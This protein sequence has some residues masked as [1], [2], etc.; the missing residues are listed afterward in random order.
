MKNYSERTQ[1]ILSKASAEKRK[2][3]R[4]TAAVSSL[5]CLALVVCVSL[6]LL[7]SQKNLPTD[8]VQ[9]SEDEYYPI[10]TKLSAYQDAHKAPTSFWD[11]MFDGLGMV[12]GSINGSVDMAPDAALPEAVPDFGVDLEGGSNK[13]EEVTDNQVQG[14]GEADRIKRSSEYI[15]YLRGE[16]LYVYS[17][18]GES[19]AEIGSFLLGDSQNL[20][21]YANQREMY[22]SADCST[23]T[24]LSPVY[25][26]GDNQKY[27]VALNLD[28]TD[29]TNIKESGR[30]YVVG[31]YLSSRFIN[32]T[33][34]LINQYTPGKMDF[35]DP[36]TFVPY[37]GTPENNKCIPMEDIYSPEELTSA[38]YTVI[39][40]LDGK[41]LEMNDTAAYLSYSTEVYVSRD[42]IYLTRSF[43]DTIEAGDKTTHTSR[44]EIS[45]LRYDS[46]KLE[47]KGSTIIDGRILNQYSMDQQEDILRVVTTIDSD[48][49]QKTSDGEMSSVAF[50]DS[51]LSASLYCIDL[52]TWETVASVEAFAPQGEEVR[53]VRFDGNNAYVCTSIV[54]TD[55]V[56]FFDLSDLNNITCKDT[57]TIDGYSLSLVDFAEG[58][59]M[60][61]GYGAS[62]DTLK[63]ELYQEGSS[64]AESY[65]KYELPYASFSQEYKACYIDRENSLIGLAVLDYSGD[66]SSE[67]YYLLLHF[68]GYELNE[69]TRIPIDGQLDMTRGVY[70]DDWFYVLSDSFAVEKIG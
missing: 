33:L 11:A 40:K 46:E 41:T 49:Y 23:I 55:P 50:L 32:G 68:D 69:V 21:R 5:T 60:G 54:L 14:V 38:R 20:A 39:C 70:I 25:N 12:G 22:L 16:S 64:T 7:L 35:T 18:A 31:N 24:I 51:V 27:T 52:N 37:Y 6:A 62:F 13:Y 17:I 2:R 47:S 43:T 59:L 67:M 45:R 4:I 36:S 19:S 53:S 57:G 61:I 63:I 1:D 8:L 26:D 9:F 66:S 15:Y 30:M 28:V 3:R 58:Y 29:P 48:T 10:I 34:Y 56:F 42:S 65:C 44:T